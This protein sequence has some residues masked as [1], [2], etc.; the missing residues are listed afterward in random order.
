MSDLPTAEQSQRFESY[1]PVGIPI[2]GGRRPRGTAIRYGSRGE[3]DNAKLLVKAAREEHCAADS[4]RSAAGQ[5][6]AAEIRAIQGW[7]KT[8]E[9]RHAIVLRYSPLPD[10]VRW[11]DEVE[12][13]IGVYDGHNGTAAAEFCSSHM[14]R[15]IFEE[16]DRSRQPHPT[17]P[18]AGDRSA[19]PTFSDV[20]YIEA[21]LER[22]FQRCDDEFRLASRGEA[23]D[24]GTTVA[25]AVISPTWIALATLGDARCGLRL[26]D[27]TCVAL[28]S[29][30]RPPVNEPEARRVLA[31]GATVENGRVNGMLSVSRAIGDFAFKP[32][33]APPAR[34][35]V[36]TRPDVAIVPVVPGGPQPHVLVLG[37]DGVWEQLNVAD[38]ARRLAESSIGCLSTVLQSCCAMNQP[39]TETG[40]MLHGADNVTLGAAVF[41]DA[42]TAT[43][44]PA[45]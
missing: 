28:E 37:C 39:L 30:H 32:I 12:G 26:T 8:M 36:I 43:T 1:G 23:G 19:S 38:V 16:L 33:D 9:D 45:Q 42:C 4:M 22:A 5:Q 7:R 24:S 21:S 2:S 35:P 27:G 31:T 3:A 29:D 6:I 17:S 25:C 20:R 15:I 44:V 11:P 40:A 34:H 41:A 10:S 14:H 13:F 18:R